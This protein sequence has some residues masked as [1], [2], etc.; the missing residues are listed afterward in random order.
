M[1]VKWMMR[2]KVVVLAPHQMMLVLVVPL[3]Y[4]T[5]AAAGDVGMSNQQALLGPLLVQMMVWVAVRGLC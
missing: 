5:T 3:A 4:A 2:T 1:W